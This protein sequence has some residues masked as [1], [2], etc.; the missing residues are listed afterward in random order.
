M[1]SEEYY[2]VVGETPPEGFTVEE[3]YKVVSETPS[4]GFTAEE[5]N[6]ITEGPEK[7][8]SLEDLDKAPEV[9]GTQEHE[10]VKDAVNNYF[11]KSFLDSAFEPKPEQNIDIGGENGTADL[12]LYAPEKEKYVA[13]AEAK[14]GKDDANYGRRQ[15]F[16]YL[17]AK[18]TRFGVFANSLDCNAWVF[19]E[20]LRHFRFRKIESFDFEKEIAEGNYNMPDKPLELKDI[21]RDFGSVIEE[22]LKSQRDDVQSAVKAYFSPIRQ[23]DWK[24]ELKEKYCNIQIGF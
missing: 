13:I 19:Y 22:M 1:K 24:C 11:S 5:C 9:E 14:R 15:L 7:A 21:K 4:E 18:N 20:N 8:D 10:K 2:R 6:K 23:Q 16:S 3:R 17:C 12:V